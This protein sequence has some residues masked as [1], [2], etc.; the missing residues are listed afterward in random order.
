M[1][2]TMFACWVRKQCVNFYHLKQCSLM[3]ELPVAFIFSNDSLLSLSSPSLPLPVAT[4]HHHSVHDLY[5]LCGV[6]PEKPRQQGWLHTA[7]LWPWYENTFKTKT[8]SQWHAVL[9]QTLKPILKNVVRWRHTCT[10]HYLTN[11]YQQTSQITEFNFTHGLEILN[12]F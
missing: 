12:L 9:N 2:S 10:Q 6:I 5:F 8:K 7:D 3:A 1:C 4:L 11:I